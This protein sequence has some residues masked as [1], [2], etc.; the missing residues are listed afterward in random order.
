VKKKLQI[1]RNLSC[2]RTGRGGEAVPTRGDGGQFCASVFYGRPF[3]L[4]SQ[5]YPLQL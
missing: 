4:T 2:V 5:L 1:F 3:T